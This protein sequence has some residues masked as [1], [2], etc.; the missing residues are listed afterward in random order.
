MDR[1]SRRT[2]TSRSGYTLMIPR[3]VHMMN[4]KIHPAKEVE[5]LEDHG[6]SASGYRKE[7]TWEKDQE[8]IVQWT[9]KQRRPDEAQVGAQSSPPQDR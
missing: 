5:T 1:S 2:H 9:K 4:Q 7:T 6:R 3:K 8:P